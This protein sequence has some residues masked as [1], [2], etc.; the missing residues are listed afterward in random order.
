MLSLNSKT[1]AAFLFLVLA[2]LNLVFAQTD[3][4]PEQPAV[5]E[6]FVYSWTDANG[7]VHLTDDPG[8]V[9]KK[10]RNKIQKKAEP[11]R[12]EV[13]QGA[14]PAPEFTAP[15]SDQEFEQNLLFRMVGLCRIAGRRTDTAILLRD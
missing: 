4:A 7:V 13:Q 14:E 10:Y 8:Q 9:P 1:I 2:M 6:R 11:P 15:A 12:D 5:K 3:P